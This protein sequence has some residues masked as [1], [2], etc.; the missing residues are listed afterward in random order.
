MA[1]RTLRKPMRVFRIGDP[2]GRHP[3]Y[4]AE[5]AARYEARWHKKGQEVIY[6]SENYST[7]MLEKLVHFNGVMPPNNHFVRISIPVGTSY[8]IVTKDSLPDWLRLTRAREFGS[9]WIDDR[10]SAVLVVPSYVAREE[11]N[12]LINPNHTDA[13]LIEPG[14]EKP[15]WWD[16]RIVKSK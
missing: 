5:G 7:A 12:V 1:P 6:T 16:P 10:R 14:L 13:Q 15:I 9:K 11:R 2:D 8:Q 3:I 4:S